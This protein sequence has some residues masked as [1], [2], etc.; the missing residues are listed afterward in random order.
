VEFTPE[1]LFNAYSFSGRKILGSRA[2]NLSALLAPVEVKV[3]F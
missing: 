1:G 2:L 3:G